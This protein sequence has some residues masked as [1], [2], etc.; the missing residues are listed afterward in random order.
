[1]LIFQ[2][3][4]SHLIPNPALPT[5]LRHAWPWCPC[6]VGEQSL[7]CSS[8]ARQKP[9]GAQ[10]GHEVW[11]K[12]Q[13]RE[14]EAGL[15]T[16]CDGQEGYV[17][18][19]SAGHGA[20]LSSLTQSVDFNGH[21][22]RI[23]EEMSLTELWMASGK[24]KNMSP[25]EWKRYAGANFIKKVQDD[26]GSARI[27][28]RTQRGGS[29]GSGGTLAHWQIALEYARYLSP[30][31]AMVCNQIVKD[32]ADAKPEIAQ[33]VINRATPKAVA[34][35]AAT[36]IEHT[37]DPAAAQGLLSMSRGTKTQMMH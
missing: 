2:A 32:F 7:G 25:F 30:E 22:I 35:I 12:V 10:L 16:G 19:R 29:G 27:A 37:M 6:L 5:H 21:A 31:L 15:W 17:F 20:S 28:I 34:K 11:S 36:D 26:A 14:A 23:A 33:S 3:Q 13:R 24:P 8:G 18:H 4:F 1:M 9:H